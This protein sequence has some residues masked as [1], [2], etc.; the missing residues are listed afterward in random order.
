MIDK[1]YPSFI[2]TKKKDTA[3]T[4]LYIIKNIAANE[5]KFNITRPEHQIGSKKL[6]NKINKKIDKIFNEKN[7]IYKEYKELFD[8]I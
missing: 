7:L 2:S 8:K 3:K 1:N 5:N 4:V 6:L